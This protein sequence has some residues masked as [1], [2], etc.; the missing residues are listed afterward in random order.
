VKLVISVF[1]LIFDVNSP[2]FDHIF[3]FDASEV[4]LACGNNSLLGF[5]V[6]KEFSE[7]FEYL[8]FHLFLM[9]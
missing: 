4:N 7:G 2:E 6:F 8:G 3:C 1:L 9:D 5:L